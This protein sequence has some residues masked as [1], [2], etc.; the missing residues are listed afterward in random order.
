MESSDIKDCQGGL[1]SRDKT[2]LENE[3]KIEI[4]TEKVIKI[5]IKPNDEEFEEKTKTDS[6]FEKRKEMHENRNRQNRIFS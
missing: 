6:F 1:K 2:E 5:K 4:K 3:V